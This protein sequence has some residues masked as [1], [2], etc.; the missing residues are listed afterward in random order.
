M[1]LAG[2]E[3]GGTK[4]I[5][6]IGDD[7]GK[8]LARSQIPTTTT[9]ETMTQVIDFLK[10]HEFSALGVAC[11]GPIDPNPHSPTY[12]YITSTPKTSWRHYDI[13]GTL[14]RA[15]PPVPVFFDTDVNGAALG[16]YYWGNGKNIN[17]FIY[18]TVGTGIGGGVMIDGKLLHGTM[19]PEL[20]HILIPQDLINDPFPGICPYHGNCLEGLA[21]GPAIK[22]RWDVESALD[23]HASHPAWDFEADYLAKAMT[24]YILC[25]SPERIILGGGVMQQQQ[26]LPLIQAKT[27]QLLAG[28]IENQTITSIEKTIVLAALGQEAGNMGALALARLALTTTL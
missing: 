20:G 9:T 14:T 24:N 11:F 10:K 4:F 5:I 12:G 3:A 8:V 27:K 15:L 7:Q 25:F 21:S 6:V 28:Y 1:K 2:I 26:L 17:N 22:S 16:E 13:V 18:L 19:H 23:L